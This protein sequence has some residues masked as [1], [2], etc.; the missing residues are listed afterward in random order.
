MIRITG[1]KGLH[2]LHE[3]GCH[4]FLRIKSKTVPLK[5]MGKVYE[6]N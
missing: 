6:L 2:K 3:L 5:K 4:I 1:P